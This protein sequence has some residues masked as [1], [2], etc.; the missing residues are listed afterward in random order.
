MRVF[1][2][3]LIHVHLRVQ[4]ILTS[5]FKIGLRKEV[6]FLHTY[7]CTCVLQCTHGVSYY[8]TTLVLGIHI[9]VHDR[10]CI[11]FAPLRYMYCIYT[12][13]LFLELFHGLLK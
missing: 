3:A 10:I 4:G 1:H 6:R 5:I 9:H 2:H 12:H 8:V 11:A 7:M 13:F